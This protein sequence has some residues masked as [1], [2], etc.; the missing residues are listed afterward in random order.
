MEG[1]NKDE[2]RLMKEKTNTV[3][4]IK[5]VK[6]WFFKNSSEIYKPLARMI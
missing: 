5:K 3:E 4:K 1:I 2:S 6:S